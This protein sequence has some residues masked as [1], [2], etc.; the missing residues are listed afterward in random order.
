LYPLTFLGLRAL[1]ALGWIGTSEG[2]LRLPFACVGIASVPIMALAGRRLVGA[3]P[4]LLAAG[5]IAIDPWHEFWSQNARGYVL[6]FTFAAVAANRAQAWVETH[7]TRDF[8]A[9]FVAIVL[10]TACH[11]TAALQVAGLAAFF[12]LQRMAP[13]DRRSWIRLAGI[14]VGLV[15]VLPWLVSHFAFFQG[16]IAAK[17]DPSLMHFVQTAG[18][19]FRP[20]VLLVA[21]AGL[22][23]AARD[24]DRDRT[25]L[26]A[27]LFVVPFFVLFVI[28]GQLVK[29]T[30]RY[31]F[32]VLP[33]V[34]WLAA[35]ACVRLAQ[36]LT[37]GSHGNV[38]TRRAAAAVLPMLLVAD[39]GVNM[40]AY[41]EVQHGQRAEWRAACDFVR[42]S[43][44]AKGVRVLTINDP[45]L[46]YY[47]R[48]KHWS[49]SKANPY[50]TI[51]VQTLLSWNIDRQD[52]E[53]KEKLPHAP[54]GE[55]HLAWH[56]K[57]AREAGVPFLVMVT[58]PELGYEDWQDGS[59]WRTL[60]RDYRIVL[61][62]PC[63]VGPKDE[64]IYIFV[65]KEG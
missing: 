38:W 29:V 8:V 13:T 26:L 14:V 17:S 62:L 40:Y 31:A 43:A 35:F 23:F 36:A 50:P 64:S 15:L 65:P 44:S 59:V 11:S 61:H 25:L 30:A 1:L 56:V 47:L 3:W 42:S 28:G 27:C 39:Y 9:A 4:A 45:T 21:L 48:P 58:L 12:W 18:F 22:W 6:A 24:L 34:A 2:W 53:D 10:G 33:I 41:H 54:G 5:F 20:L 7:R 32:C 63:W 51:N 57:L 19:Y 52:P 49:V 37:S 16:F 60:Q 55:A 46:H